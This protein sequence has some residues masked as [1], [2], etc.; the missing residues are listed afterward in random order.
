MKR[1]LGD[2]HLPYTVP[3]PLPPTPKAQLPKPELLAV[4][5]RYIYDDKLWWYNKQTG[6][7]YF[8]ATGTKEVPVTEFGGCCGKNG[9]VQDSSVQDDS[10]DDDAESTATGGG[11][12]SVADSSTSGRPP[13]A[14]PRWNLPPI[15][16]SACTHRAFYHNLYSTEAGTNEPPNGIVE[17]MNVSGL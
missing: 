13:A 2:D 8:E 10:D 5:E 4:W 15:D 3:Q 11:S 9:R 6:D 1:L 17:V 14:G 7:Y 12:T 16:E